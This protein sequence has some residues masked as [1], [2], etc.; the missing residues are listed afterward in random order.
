MFE[1][2]ITFLYTRDL[3]STAAFYEN[4]LGLP[5]VRDQGD[6]RIYQISANGLLGFCERDTAPTHPAP[7]IVTFITQGVQDWYARMQARG[8]VFENRPPSTPNT[9]LSTAFCATPTDI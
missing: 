6:C 9:T 3:A 8:V 5:L 4:A 1:Q 7:L 2:F